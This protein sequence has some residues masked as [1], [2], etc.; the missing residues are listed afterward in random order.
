[1]CVR[2]LEENTDVE[3]K[4]NLASFI[5]SILCQTSHTVENSTDFIKWKREYLNPKTELLKYTEQKNRN[6]MIKNEDGHQDHW[7]SI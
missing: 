3:K 2:N 4:K 6:K 7:N 5:E 1:M